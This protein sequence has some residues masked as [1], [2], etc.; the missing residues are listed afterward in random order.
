MCLATFTWLWCN[1]WIS[2]GADGNEPFFHGISE[3]IDLE[4]PVSSQAPILCNMWKTSFIG[5]DDED[6]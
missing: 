2:R 3:C 5:G 4:M 1:Q 6:L